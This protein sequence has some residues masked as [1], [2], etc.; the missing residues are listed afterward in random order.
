MTDYAADSF[1]S[2]GSGRSGIAAL[3]DLSLRFVADGADCDFLALSGSGVGP[4]ALSAAGQIL[5]VADS[6]VAV[7]RLKASDILRKR[8]SEIAFDDELVL[9]HRRN[10]RDVL[11]G[12]LIGFGAGFDFRAFDQF[13]RDGGSDS[14]DVPEGVFDALVPRD[15]NS[16]DSRHVSWVLRFNLV[17][18]CDADC[19]SIR[20]GPCLCV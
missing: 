4:G 15:V 3:L 5:A 12:D 11:V 7:D 10:G 9:Q 19:A 6:P 1:L 8:A 18:V 17:S 2:G 14:V 16:Y 13:R 20:R